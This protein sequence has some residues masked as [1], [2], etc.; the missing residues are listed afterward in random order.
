MGSRPILNLSIRI[1]KVGSEVDVHRIFTF[2]GFPCEIELFVN[3]WGVQG[4]DVMYG[5]C[6]GE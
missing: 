2:S 6:R 3:C 5:L 4:C 1:H